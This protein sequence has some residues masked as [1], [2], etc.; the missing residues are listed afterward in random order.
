MNFY[1]ITTIVLLAVL[2]VQAFAPNLIP[3]T[4][5]AAT[6]AIGC[7]TMTAGLKPI[8]KKCSDFKLSLNFT[9]TGSE[10][11]SA[12]TVAR[13]DHKHDSVY[14]NVSGD[15]MTGDLTTT[16]DISAAGH[17]TVKAG[18]HAFCSS[19]NSSVIHSF[20][21]VNDTQITISNGGSNG[22][23]T[24]NFG[25]APTFVIVSPYGSDAQSQRG[26]SSDYPQSNSVTFYKFITTTGERVNGDIYVLVY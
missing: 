12:A 1:K 24:I 22:V 6:D 26:A 15:S 20:N 8:G 9:P 14:V 4:A 17:G 3:T 19:S 10:N 2:M 21:N 18:V 23:C 13:G 16:G 5:Q 11:G 25:F 7:I